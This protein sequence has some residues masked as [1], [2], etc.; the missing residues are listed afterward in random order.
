MFEYHHKRWNSSGLFAGYESAGL[1][2]SNLN[3][4]KRTQIILGDPEKSRTKG[5]RDVFSYRS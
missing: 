4:G 2:I 1:T 3:V 5:D